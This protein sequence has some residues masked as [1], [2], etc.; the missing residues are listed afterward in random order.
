MKE[1]VVRKIRFAK[2][3]LRSKIRKRSRHV[4]MKG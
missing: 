3:L 1:S 4:S 2:V